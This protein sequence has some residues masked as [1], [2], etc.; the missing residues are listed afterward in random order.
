M[1]Q[2]TQL[3]SAGLC[4]NRGKTQQD[5]YNMYVL[6]KTTL[7]I[8]VVQIEMTGKDQI[9]CLLVTVYVCLCKH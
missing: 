9:V 2:F 5:Q 4:D 7:F 8:F 6:I 1:N 3:K